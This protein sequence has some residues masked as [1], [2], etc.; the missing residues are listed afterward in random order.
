VILDTPPVL[1]VSDARAISRQADAVV[2]VCR[3]SRTPRRAAAAALNLLDRDG[4]PVAGVAL[5]MVD[6]AARRALS[7]QDGPYYQA[8]YSAYN[9]G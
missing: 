4:A 9:N 7:D 8:A 6:F 1:A 3:W 2:F 5:T